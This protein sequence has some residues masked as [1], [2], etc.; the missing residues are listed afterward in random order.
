MTYGERLQKAM[1]YKG[2]DQPDLVARVIELR[3]IEGL[4][5][6][7]TQ[8]TVSKSLKSASSGYNSWYAKALDVSAEWLENGIGDMVVE[9]TDAHSNWPFAFD[10]SRFLRLHPTKKHFIERAVLTMLEGF[11]AEMDDLPP[12]KK[13]RR[14]GK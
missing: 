14:K 9:R 6:K 12:P 7:I 2:F 8:Q 1:D 5:S 11:E 4:E 10:E 13:T 3:K